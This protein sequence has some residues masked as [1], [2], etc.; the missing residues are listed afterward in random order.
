M[1]I[2]ENALRGRRVK[3]RSEAALRWR[4]TCAAPRGRDDSSR[5]TTG[6]S[7]KPSF[8]CSF[9]AAVCPALSSRIVSGVSGFGTRKDVL[10]T[11]STE[12]APPQQLQVAP[13]SV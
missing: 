11:T 12:R 9:L 10:V 8:S 3:L 4:S 6:D 5:T 2:L 13:M 7:W 1:V